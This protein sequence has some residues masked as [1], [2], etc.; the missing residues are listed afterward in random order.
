[1]SG[2]MVQVVNGSRPI[3]TR[4]KVIDIRLNQRLENARSSVESSNSRV[5]PLYDAFLRLTTADLGG[6]IVFNSCMRIGISL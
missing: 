6:V 5:T 4:D 1:M 3:S 2:A